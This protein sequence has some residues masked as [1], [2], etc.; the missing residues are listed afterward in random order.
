M[1]CS[2]TALPFTASH[3]QGDEE[4]TYGK[5]VIGIRVSCTKQNPGQ[6]SG[7]VENRSDVRKDQKKMGEMGPQQGRM[8]MRMRYTEI[9]N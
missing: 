7:K 6:A 3:H 8:E 4:G 1:A 2:G 9:G 5:C